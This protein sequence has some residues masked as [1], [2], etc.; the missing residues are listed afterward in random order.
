MDKQIKKFFRTI[1]QR[2]I[3]IPLIYKYIERLYFLS[4][5]GSQIYW[6]YRY[7]SGKTSGSGSYSALA[8]FKAEILN[9]FIK[10]NNIRS[11]IEF[12]CGD[13]N[14]LALAEYPRYIGLDVSRT[15]IEM[16]KMKFENDKSKSFFLYDTLCFV[17]NH[18]VFKNDLAIS[19]DVIY[20]LVED[21]IYDKYMR[22]LFA[23]SNKYVI[24]YS[25]NYEEHQSDHV[26]RREF[27]KWVEL[28]AIDW[29]LLKK[30]NNK[31]PYDPL[32]PM[33]TSKSDFYIF[34]KIH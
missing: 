3:K 21:E 30:I 2:I 8:R 33:N 23:S 5:P 31:Y 26:R 14:Q 22:A 28:N 18:G 12:G 13:G 20:H 1:I 24:I 15:A 10:E 19:I 32:D 29:K 17:D 11:V 4:F 9:S 6:E 34:Q 25:S 27:T 16:C 7:R